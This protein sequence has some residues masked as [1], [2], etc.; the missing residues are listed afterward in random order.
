MSK[1]NYV[2]MKEKNK[3]RYKPVVDIASALFVERNTVFNV[4][5][6]NDATGQKENV[7]PSPN[8]ICDHLLPLSLI[9]SFV[10]S[11]NKYCEKRNIHYCIV[12]KTGNHHLC[13]CCLPCI[14]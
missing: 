10:A 6:K 5:V 12:G 7:V 13:L 8:V 4:R 9:K 14:T 2:H 1:T 11:S 3:K